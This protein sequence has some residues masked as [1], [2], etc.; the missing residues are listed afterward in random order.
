MPI[1]P[2]RDTRARIIFYLEPFSIMRVP[3]YNEIHRHLSLS[4]TVDK[5]TRPRLS[6]N[7]PPICLGSTR[8]AH[9]DQAMS[10]FSGNVILHL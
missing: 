7:D 3:G 8:R 5:E 4:P 10:H 1:A 9:H 6:L 2:F